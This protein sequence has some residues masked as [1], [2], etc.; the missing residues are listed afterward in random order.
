MTTP[1]PPGL[2]AIYNPDGSRKQLYSTPSQAPPY[3]PNNPNGLGGMLG[4]WAHDLIHKS[5]LPDFAKANT[6]L[7]GAGIGAAVGGGIGAT[8]S[9]VNNMFGSGAET[10]TPRVAGIGAIIGSLMGMWRQR[11]HQKPASVGDPLVQLLNR[12]NDVPNEVKAVLMYI[13][14]NMSAHDKAQLLSVLRTVAG[15]SIGAVAAMTMSRLGLLPAAVGFAMGGLA[16][17][18]SVAPSYNAEPHY[19]FQ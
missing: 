5:K 11:M 2:R 18:P 6:T 19:L 10:S 9:G 17:R 15:A 8:L 1:L 7:G 14:Q 4:G 3:N 16:T 12:A 13:A